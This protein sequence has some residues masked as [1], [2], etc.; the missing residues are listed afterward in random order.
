M[1]RFPHTVEGIKGILGCYR[2]ALSMLELP[3][4]KSQ[5]PRLQGIGL[6]R[7]TIPHHASIVRL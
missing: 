3:P 6:H 7:V 2:L 5:S 4:H 1:G